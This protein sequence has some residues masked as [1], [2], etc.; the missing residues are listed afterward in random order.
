VGVMNRVNE[1]ADRSEGFK[2]KN[3]AGFK[4]LVELDKIIAEVINV[5]SRQSIKVQSEYNN[6]VNR[7][8]TEMQI[9]LD[10]PLENL[11]KVT[12]SAIVEGIKRVREGNLFIEPGY[13]GQYGKINIFSSQGKADNQQKLF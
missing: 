7:V 2:P 9:L 8:G 4:K 6:L 11:Q 12:S 5:K 3:V 1:L 10:E 13:D